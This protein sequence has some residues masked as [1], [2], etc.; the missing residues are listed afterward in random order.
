MALANSVC[1]ADSMTKYAFVT[2][3]VVSS[4]GKG[5]SSSLPVGAVLASEELVDIN[6]DANLS[7]THG[8]NALCCAAALANLEFLTSDELQGDFEERCRL[9]EKR[10]NDLLQYS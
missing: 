7:S 8:G 2:G 4:L 5:I 3:G 6:L 9:F 10:S 1:G